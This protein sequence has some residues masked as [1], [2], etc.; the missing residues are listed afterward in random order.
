M[1]F[2]MLMLSQ[3]ASAEQAFAVE[4]SGTGWVSWYYDEDSPALIE[5]ENLTQIGV[6]ID[7]CNKLGYPFDIY[8]GDGDLLYSCGQVLV[9]ANGEETYSD[10]GFIPGYT[11]DDEI[12]C[13]ISGPEAT[14]SE[15]Y[16]YLT[17]CSRT[18]AWY[19][20]SLFVSFQERQMLYCN[21][22]KG[23]I[24][25]YQWNCNKK[26]FKAQGHNSALMDSDGKLYLAIIAKE[27]RDEPKYYYGWVY[28]QDKTILE[29]ALSEM[30]LIVGT[31]QLIP[32]PSNWVLLLLGFAGLA[33]RR[34]RS[35][36]GASEE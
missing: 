6:C 23:E 15:G 17:I 25:N 11:P 34:Q 19:G 30:P 26:P 36:R 33:L 5:G 24:N 31:G 32:E 8:W 3:R 10:E 35:I 4:S 16:A 9:D 20:R 12:T 18:N 22:L 28:L 29:S 27:G 2:P 13:W 14:Q 7:P 1:L 21:V